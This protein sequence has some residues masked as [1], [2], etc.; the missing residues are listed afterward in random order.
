MFLTDLWHCARA[1]NQLGVSVPLPSFV[2]ITLAR[3][4]ITRRIHIGRDLIARVIRRCFGALIVNKLVDDFK[5]RI[6]FN[7]GVYDAELACIS[8][9]LGIW[10]SEV[11]RWPRP[12]AVIKLLNVV[13][14][15][16]GEIETLFTSGTMPI[17][18]LNIVQQTIDIISP[19]LVL[20]GAFACGDLPMDQ[21]LLLREICLKIA[22]AQPDSR[23]SD[24]TVGI[25]DQLQQ[26][27]KQLPTVEYKM[28]RCTSSIFDSQFVRG[29]SNSTT[30]P[31]YEVR[32]RR[33][34]SM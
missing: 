11:L 17:D 25:L 28:R 4:E 3:P 32:R 33:S 1:Y 31:E 8:S 23:F 14:L 9:I 10:P 15:V 6:S 16:S 24:Q 30:Q 12:S 34:K 2:R 13:S 19:E 26:I 21:V 20:G 27:S 5:S 22:N 29:R 18:V 7:S